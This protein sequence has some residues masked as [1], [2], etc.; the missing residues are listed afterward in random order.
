VVRLSAGYE[1]KLTD[2]ISFVTEPYLTVPL[3]GVGFGKV[4]LYSSGI[5]FSLNIKPFAKNK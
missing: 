5:L 3:A 1:K 4:K 2:K